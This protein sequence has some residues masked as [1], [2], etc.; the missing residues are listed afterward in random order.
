MGR[1]KKKLEASLF[2]ALCSV[3]CFLLFS[4]DDCHALGCS[5]LTRLLSTMVSWIDHS[6]ISAYSRLR[7][8][9]L[10]SRII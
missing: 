3:S 4:S 5:T 7:D 2:F 1:D 8:C 6:V 10:K 9:M